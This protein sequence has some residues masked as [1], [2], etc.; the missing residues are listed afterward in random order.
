MILI[1]EKSCWDKEGRERCRCFPLD[2]DVCAC[3]RACVWTSLA[4]S[5]SGVSSSC[6][7]YCDYV[8]ERERGGGGEDRKERQLDWAGTEV[9]KSRGENAA[10]S[11]K[12]EGRRKI[13]ITLSIFF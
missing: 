12:L 4:R 9:G 13:L 1:Q 2:D 3:M 7:C 6:K 8:R 10:V 5:Q 11:L